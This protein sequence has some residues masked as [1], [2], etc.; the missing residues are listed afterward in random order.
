MSHFRK[1]RKQIPKDWQKEPKPPVV[2]AALPL[3]GALLPHWDNENGFRHQNRS[4]L[5][6]AFFVCTIVRFVL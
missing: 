3:V 1:A 5:V 4:F 2:E 6:R